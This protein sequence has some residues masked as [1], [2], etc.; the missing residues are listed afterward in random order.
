MKNKL[1]FIICLVSMNYVNKT[2]NQKLRFKLQITLTFSNVILKFML[3]DID[4][5]G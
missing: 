5:V 1:L 3:D 2:Y 4:T